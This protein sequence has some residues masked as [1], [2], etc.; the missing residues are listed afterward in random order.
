LT[1][2][3]LRRLIRFIRFNPLTIV[4]LLLFINITVKYCTYEHLFLISDNRHYTFYVWSRFFQRYTLFRYLIT[5]A[6]VI[7]LI[8]L[9][10]QLD[11]R[12]LL[13]VLLL[14]LSITLLTI[15]Q[16]LLELRYFILPFVLLRLSIDDRKSS[17]LFIELFQA[18]LVNGITVYV[19]C[20]QTFVWPT[21][22]NVLQRFMY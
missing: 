9:Y 17:K 13:N 15:F 6:Y 20:H 4:V 12:S 8:L 16:K 18:V 7:A 19:F 3:N 1:I 2:D 21:Q 22:P 10:F 11:D 5:P 14:F